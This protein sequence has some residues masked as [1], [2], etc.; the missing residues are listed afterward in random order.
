M[1]PPGR[2]G[3]PGVW[4]ISGPALRH[5]KRHP[6]ETP[7]EISNQKDMSEDFKSC[8]RRSIA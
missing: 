6:M 8:R 5:L 3:K 4:R 7:S 2:F 1:P